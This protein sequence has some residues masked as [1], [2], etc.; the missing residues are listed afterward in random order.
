VFSQQELR[1]LFQAPQRLKQRVILCLIYSAGLRVSEVCKL[2][3]TDVDFDR[4]QLH[5]RESK[6][7]RSR[8][9]VLSKLIAKGLRQYIKGSKPKGYLFNGRDKGTP[10]GHSAVQQTFRLSMEK[11]SIQKEACVHTLRHSFVLTLKLQ[12]HA[13][14]PFI[15]TRC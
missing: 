13:C 8:Y 14:H 1:R 2:K 7:N 4:S 5:I 6:N 10:L 15:G 3:L 9:V 12:R 11:A